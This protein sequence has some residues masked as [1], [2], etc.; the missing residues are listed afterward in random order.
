MF[1]RHIDF[2]FAPFRA[3]NNKI[4]GMRNIKGNIKVD[5]NRSKALANRG[6]AAAGRVGGYTQ[7]MP[8]AAGQPGQPQQQQP[9]QQQTAYGQQ[10]PQYGQQQYGQSQQGAQQMQQPGMPAQGGAPM[11]APGMPGAPQPGAPAPP[12]IRTTCFWSGIRVLHAV[13]AATDK[14]WD[15]PYCAQIA[16]QASIPE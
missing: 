8:Q 1:L 3:I 10:Q 5:I 11:G 16:Q 4:I 12:P 6:K 9:N 14:S 13:R 15:L 2:I 7:Q